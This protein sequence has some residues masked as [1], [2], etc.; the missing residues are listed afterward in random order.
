[1]TPL[2]RS[3]LELA[4]AGASAARPG[5]AVPRGSAARPVPEFRTDFAFWMVRE[6]LALRAAPVVRS[7]RPGSAA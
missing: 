4:V 6:I 2:E 3:R 7:S 1:M 5:S